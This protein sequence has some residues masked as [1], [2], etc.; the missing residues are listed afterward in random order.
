MRFNNTSFARPRDKDYD[1]DRPRRPKKKKGMSVGMI[2]LIVFGSLGAVSCVACIGVGTLAYYGYVKAQEA[3][4]DLNA[5]LPAGK[6]KVLLNQSAKLLMTDPN[7]EFNTGFNREN[8][9]HKA[10]SVQLEKGKTYVVTLASNEMDS[11][12]FVYDPNGKMVAFDDDSGGGF[13][14]LNS[15]IHLTAEHSGNYQIACTVLGLVPPN[16]G[17]FT[18]N[19]RER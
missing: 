1:D 8:K 5:Q 7:K 2:L 17:N 9:P 6:G 15:R 12:L 3:M 10:F 19:V 4:D 18:V 16:G 14:G 13:T 11:F